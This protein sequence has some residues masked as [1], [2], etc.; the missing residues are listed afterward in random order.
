MHLEPWAFVVIRN[1]A[2][3]KRDSNRAKSLLMAEAARHQAPLRVPGVSASDEHAARLVADPAFNI[4]YNAGTLIAI[5][6]RLKGTFVI[7]DCW[8]AAENLMLAAHSLGL[9]SC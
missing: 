5:C 9:G 4:L 3:L 7:A 2:Q 1:R 6:G 8:L